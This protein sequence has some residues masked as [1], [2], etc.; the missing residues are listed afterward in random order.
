M[1]HEKGRCLFSVWDKTYTPDMI[2][3]ALSF[4]QKN[5]LTRAEVKL[6]QTDK[7]VYVETRKDLEW[8]LG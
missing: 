7:G 2:E 3:L 4:L 8:N 6:I 1:K 5:N